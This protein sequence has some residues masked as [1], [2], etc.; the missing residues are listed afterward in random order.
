[1]GPGQRWIERGAAGQS[2]VRREWCCCVCSAAF[3]RLG[4]WRA[5]SPMRTE[6]VRRRAN[7]ADTSQPQPLRAGGQS[8][9]GS[10][11]M[12]HMDRSICSLRRR[13]G[14]PRINKWVKVSRCA[15]PEGE[16][17]RIPQIS[18]CVVL[19]LTCACAQ[20]FCKGIAC[21]F[22]SD[23]CVLSSVVFVVFWC[24]LCRPSQSPSPSPSPA[25]ISPI[26]PAPFVCLCLPA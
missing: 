9:W 13:Q 24:F 26:A 6:N 2:S 1:M 10:A 5:L 21:D 15:P 12:Q 4:D 3:V 22:L 11:H 17:C 16:A 18:P 20:P 25:D 8:V 19:L 14:A 7:R 23:L